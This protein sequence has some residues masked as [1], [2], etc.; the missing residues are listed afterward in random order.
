MNN[1]KADT[2]SREGG[3]RMQIE[4]KGSGF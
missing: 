4:K 2:K 3:I 1:K